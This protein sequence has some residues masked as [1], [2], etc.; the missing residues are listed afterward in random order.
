MINYLQGTVRDIDDKSISLLAGDIGYEILLHLGDKMKLKIGER[1]E[2]FIYSH[3]REDQFTLFGFIDKG[4]KEI[5]RKLISVS[6]VGPKSALSLL[7]VTNANIIIRAIEGNNADILPK[8]P[9]LGKKTI[10][11]IILELKG[12]MDNNIIIQGESDDMKDARLALESLGYTARDI[13]EILNKLHPDLK[14]NDIIRESL[15]ILA[16]TK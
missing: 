10:E 8:V 1:I 14:M 9:G 4:E 13:S 11:K 3:I 12:K 5:F 16:K 7:S 6:G 15:K 2:L